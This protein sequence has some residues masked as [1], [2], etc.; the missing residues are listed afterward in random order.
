[1][2][3]RDRDP[4]ILQSTPLKPSNSDENREL[5]RIVGRAV[6]H[7]GAKI[8]N[9]AKGVALPRLDAMLD[10]DEAGAPRP[11]A[12]TAMGGAAIAVGLLIGIVL[13]LWVGSF[14]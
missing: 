5:L 9:A 4:S 13:L 1:M 10:E 7:N 2:G 8:V 6:A 12:E 3:L 11:F 14:L